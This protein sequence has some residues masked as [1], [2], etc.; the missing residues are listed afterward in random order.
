M[1]R[2]APLLLLLA[3]AAPAP[4]AAPVD[5]EALVRR[6]HPVNTAVNPLSPFT[7][8]NGGFAMTVDVTGLQSFPDAYTRGLP[9]ATQSDWGWHSFPDESGY[10]LADTFEDFATG[11]RLVPY[12]T[13]Q[14]S[15][16]GAWLRSNPHR[17]GLGR[18][19]FEFL[20]EDGFLAT[21]DDITE[22]RQELSLWTGEIKSTYRVQGVPVEVTTVAHP[23]IDQVAVR[24]ESPLLQQSR[25]RIVARFPYGTGAWGIDPHD[26]DSPDRHETSIAESFPG[27]VK[28]SRRLDE[29]TYGVSLITGRSSDQFAL[30][31]PHTL[32]VTPAAR[33][34][35]EALAFI[36]Y[37]EGGDPPRGMPPEPFTASREHW[38]RFWTEGAAVDFSGSTDPRAPELERRVILSQYLTA[39]QCAGDMPPQETGLTFNSWYGVP[40][41]EMHWWHGVH[42]A[43]WDRL[44]LLERSLPWYEKILPTA[45][46]IASRQGYVGARWPK[47][48]DREGRE[49]PSGIAPLLVW[50]QPHPIYFAELAW[51]QS[52]LPDTL[53]RYRTIVFETA[54]FMA[55]FAL[56]NPKTGYYDL[57]PPLIPAQ[58]S[59]DPRSTK[60]P[61]YELAY[62]RWGLA[63]AQAWRERLGLERDP[64]WDEVLAKLAPYPH[65][66]D[67][68]ATAEG[69]WNMVDHPS[70]LGA[71]GLVPG[72]GID[73]ERMRRTLDRI[74]VEQDWDHTWGW[75]YPMIAITAAR[76]GDPAL[77]LDALLLDRQKN[78]YLPNG[79]NYQDDRLRIYLPGN[80]ALL[81][82]VAMMAGGWDGAP[83]RPAPGFPDDG[84]WVV[85]AEGFRPLP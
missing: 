64:Q 75:D 44:D 6:H 30:T 61:P 63:T 77:A 2:V 57:G 3:I 58:E 65:H 21:L 82:A 83:D 68:Y 9:L 5:R 62:W 51:R 14:T 52:P 29:F 55:D 78:T 45:R 79:H 60:N 15:P 46:G 43:L 85:R 80:G 71:Y 16:A 40:H 11:D 53:E 20:R 19:G 23:S 47:M 4:A 26:W 25:L 35:G 56:L 69:I 18:I 7:V 72:A 49:K 81:T 67:A 28:L 36:A 42:F 38:R 8:G 73:P 12:P 66:E 54:A 48:V 22:I 32:T 76:L 70:V 27:A 34:S 17:L 1:N 24:V 59:Y 84:T 33:E 41:L 39:I 74:M 13:K 10:K 50:E 31:A 37:F